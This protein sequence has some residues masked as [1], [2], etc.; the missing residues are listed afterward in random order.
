MPSYLAL[1]GSFHSDTGGG[2]CAGPQFCCGQ[3]QAQDCR[4]YRRSDGTIRRRWGIMG[5]GAGGGE[6]PFMILGDRAPTKPIIDSRGLWTADGEPR[7][8]LSVGPVA[9]LLDRFQSG[10]A[11]HFPRGPPPGLPQKLMGRN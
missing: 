7:F 9:P 10:R 1:A 5:M 8:G 4:K 6:F 2:P 3:S 11:G